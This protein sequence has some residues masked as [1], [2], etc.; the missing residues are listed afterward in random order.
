MTSKIDDFTDDDY[1]EKVSDVQKC[2]NCNNA[3]FCERKCPKNMHACKTC[4]K[5]NHE[6][7]FCGT[8]FNSIKQVKIHQKTSKI[9]IKS[10]TLTIRSFLKKVG[11]TPRIGRH[12]RMSSC[13]ELLLLHEPQVLFH[14]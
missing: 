7:Q 2:L 12:A 3:H 13:P 9:C 5:L 4:G 6:C 11:S 14:M 10:R 1:E 8:C